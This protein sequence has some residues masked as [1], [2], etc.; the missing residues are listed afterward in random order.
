MIG[1][2]SP[3]YQL[4]I[5]SPARRFL[6][7]ALPRL[8]SDT[9]AF[10]Y[11]T[12][13][14]ISSGRAFENALNLLTAHSIGITS[15]LKVCAPHSFSNRPFPDDTVRQIVAEFCALLHEREFAPYPFTDAK[16]KLRCRSTRAKL[17]YPLAD[18]VGKLRHLP[19]RIDAHTC[20]A[21]GCCVRDCPAN[22]IHMDGK[23]IRNA[24]ACVHCYRCAAVCPVKAV[25]CP[26]ERLEDM[27]RMNKRLLGC[28]Q[29]QNEVLL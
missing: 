1:I 23:A 25:V 19:I 14:G 2:G 21:C 24:S 29:P 3:V 8:R 13:G 16:K 26:L 4:R 28:E 6:A 7:A 9:T 22:A 10:V 15:A 12:Y 20:I 18:A 27:V 11:L 17:V 5:A